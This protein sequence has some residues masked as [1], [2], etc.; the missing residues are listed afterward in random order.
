MRCSG[1]PRE[2]L[3]A[4]TCKS[5]SGRGPSGFSGNSLRAG[6]ATMEAKAACVLAV[7]WRF[8]L[9]CDTAHTAQSRE[10]PFY[11]YSALVSLFRRRYVRPPGL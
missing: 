1:A 9:R 2:A 4:V 6:F 10:L 3:R 8:P 7:N 5:V 11:S